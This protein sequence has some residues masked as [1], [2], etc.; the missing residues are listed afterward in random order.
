MTH[1]TGKG[2]RRCTLLNGVLTVVAGAVPLEFFAPV[3]SSIGVQL[4]QRMGWRP[5]KGVGSKGAA[6]AAAAAT[7]KAG[8]KG[9]R[10]LAA[11]AVFGGFQGAAG[12]GGPA[13]TSDEEDEQGAP[14]SSK[15]GAVAGVSIENTPMYVLEP[16]Q[17]LHGLG[18]DP[19]EGAEVFRT[20]KRQKLAS[21]RSAADVGSTLPR[22][23]GFGGSGVPEW[24]GS[25]A[26]GVA[27][28]TGVLEESDTLGYMEDY[29]DAEADILGK[30]EK[31]NEV[32]AF[33]EGS[34]SGK[35]ITLQHP[36]PD[37]TCTASAL[38]TALPKQPMALKSVFG[39]FIRD[40]VK[41]FD[42]HTHPNS[43]QFCGM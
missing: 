11:D 19:F 2:R 33:E 9:Q 29:V 10:Q 3:S 6:A 21:A 31:R 36:Q 40:N 28:G 20:C 30:K 35:S 38:F 16:K 37:D 26:R 22:H 4:L 24:S 1:V 42:T 27:F 25:K 14:C 5:G 34:D 39:F 15:W 17:D 18:F 7:R 43:L 23:A 41:S 8:Q 13:A 12:F 32:F